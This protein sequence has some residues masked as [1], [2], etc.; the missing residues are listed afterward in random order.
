[1]N[2]VIESAGSRLGFSFDRD[3]LQ[4]L[5]LARKTDYQSADPFPH[6]A[7][8]GFL[9]LPV[10]EQ[11]M[12]EFPERDASLWHRA[13]KTWETKLSCEDEAV[14]PPSIRHVLR[15]FNSS[16]FVSFLETLTGIEGIIPDPHYR[17]GG[18]HSISRGG[19]LG[20]HAD[21]NYYKR[22][23]LHRR[24]NLLL[25]LNEDWQDDFGGKLE[26]WDK[27]MTSCV[28]A[29]APMLNRCVVFSTTDDSFHGHPDPLACPTSRSRNSLALYYYTAGRPG[30]Q[31]SK[32]HST[33][34]RQRPESLDE[35]PERKKGL[36][37][38]L[39]K[40]LTR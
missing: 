9:S 31:F 39:L 16:T 15:E 23:H 21:F 17:G 37:R 29:Y 27:Q 32:P 4:A 18:M 19:R 38:R 34:F 2:T 12:A 3:V 10:V 6:I 8:D 25:Y 33:L 1:M 40:R 22:L 26:L 13:D 7:L 28:R 36:A 11:L 14:F 5:A 35:V 30:D 24:L 20:I